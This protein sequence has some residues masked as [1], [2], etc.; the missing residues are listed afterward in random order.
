M[1]RRY[2]NRMDRYW[3]ACHLQ[4]VTTIES[5]NWN[6]WFDLWHLH[7][8][9]KA[10]GNR[11]ENRPYSY[12]LG[13]QLLMLVEQ[14]CARLTAPSQC[15]MCVYPDAND[16]AIYLHTEN[17]NE[18]GVGFLYVFSNVEWDVSDNPLLNAIV[19]TRIH[20]IGRIESEDHSY[21]VIIKK[22]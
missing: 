15:F 8:D 12:F 5:L 21:Y 14:R 6:G 9:R 13:Y 10:K 17:P 20:R 18:N 3:R 4:A 2:L 7:Y 11:A 1:D 19:D 22:N 16:D